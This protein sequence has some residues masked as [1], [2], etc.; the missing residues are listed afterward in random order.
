MTMRRTLP[1][2]E[3]L[4]TEADLARKVGLACQPASA[5]LER[6]R[7]RQHAPTKKDQ[8]AT[9]GTIGYRGVPEAVWNFHIGSYQ[10]C[11]RWLKDRT[12][13]ANEIDHYQKIFLA[14]AETIR[15]MKEIDE[16]SDAY[17]GWPGAFQKGAERQHSRDFE[18][19]MV[20]EPKRKYGGRKT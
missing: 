20:A 6:I 4:P 9:P 12:L 16:V 19:R 5:L 7:K 17:G 18:V 11:E 15:L 2:V 1:S 10:V 3:L 8:P 13:T 14:L